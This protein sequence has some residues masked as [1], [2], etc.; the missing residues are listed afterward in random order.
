M[1]IDISL[2][3]KLHPVADVFPWCEVLYTACLSPTQSNDTA[4]WVSTLPVP[5]NPP[6]PVSKRMDLSGHPHH[7]G[8]EETET[9]TD[10]GENQLD[11]FRKLGYS[12]AQVRAVLQKLGLN[13]DTNRLLGELVRSGAS[14]E[15][16]EKV[17]ENGGLQLPAMS[18]L[19]SRGDSTAKTHTN[20]A[21]TLPISQEDPGEEGDA[22]RPIVIDG[23]NVA[24]R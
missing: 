18:V 13:T 24:M 20:L 19:V 5:Q 3:P 11:L 14:P 16:M 6:R 9:P 7:P 17:K 10:P 8:Q 21:F 12:P 4:V 22:L 15:E 2:L 1:N 23:S